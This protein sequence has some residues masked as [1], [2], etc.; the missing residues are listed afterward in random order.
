LYGLHAAGVSWND[1]GFLL[2]GSSGSG[3]TT[4]TCALARSGW[5]YLSDD[6]VLLQRG[7]SGVEAL[8]FGRPFHCATPLFRYFPELAR[9]A[10]LPARGKHLVDVGPIYAGQSRPGFRPRAILFPEISSAPTSRLIPLNHTATLVRL[11]GEGAGLLHN[12]DY[13]A[14]QMEILGDLARSARGFR[15][16]H[17][18]DVH[19][20][21]SRVSTLLRRIAGPGSISQIQGG[22]TD[23]LYDAA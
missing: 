6:T 19:T 11:L 9:K 21:P 20:D 2:A 15:L 1:H 13:M 16:L 22:H 14:A 23:E 7:R 8:A 3:K 4:L 12:R 5:Q 18:T 10:P 17:G